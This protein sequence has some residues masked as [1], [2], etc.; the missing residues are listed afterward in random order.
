MCGIISLSITEWMNDWYN[1]DNMMCWL[2]LQ[3]VLVVKLWIYYKTTS[4]RNDHTVS[5]STTNKSLVVRI[6]NVFFF[7]FLSFCFLIG[8][9][10][11]TET[12]HPLFCFK[13]KKFNHF[14]FTFRCYLFQLFLVKFWDEHSSWLV[15]SHEITKNH[16]PH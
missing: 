13:S 2:L 15:F 12:M 9:V 11:K 8:F 10:C 7:S 6:M 4:I 1:S 14:A 16:F 3:V 5:V